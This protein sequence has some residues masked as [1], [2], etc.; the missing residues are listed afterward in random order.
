MLDADYEK[1]YM[2]NTKG[3]FMTHVNEVYLRDDISCGWAA[4][5]EE[6][7]QTSKLVF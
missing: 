3:K 6:G 1:H 4:C 5:D 2:I 7:Q